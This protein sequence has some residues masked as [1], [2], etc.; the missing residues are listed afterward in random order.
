MI[1][2]KS[3]LIG[4]PKYVAADIEREV[5]A[6]LQQARRTHREFAT[7]SIPVRPQPPPRG[8]EHHE[9][10]A[11]ALGLLAAGGYGGIKIDPR[12]GEITVPLT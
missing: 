8:P 1:T 7:V 10:W 12:S 5:E 4:S 6:S 9:P 2:P 3:Q 11:T